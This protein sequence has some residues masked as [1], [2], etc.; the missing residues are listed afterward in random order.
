MTVM[1]PIK[2]VAEAVKWGVAGIILIVIT[3]VFLAAASYGQAQQGATQKVVDPQRVMDDLGDKLARCEKVDSIRKVSDAADLEQAQKT[4][5]AKDAEINRL[6]A[7]II[8]SS[9]KATPDETL[10]QR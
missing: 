8:A 7:V 1:K 2:C 3:V 5:A 6:N 9:A 10:K 4:I